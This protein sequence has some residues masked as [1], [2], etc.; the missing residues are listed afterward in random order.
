[1]YFGTSKSQAD[2]SF[3]ST[4]WFILFFIPIFPLRS[5]RII[6]DSEWDEWHS[7][8]KTYQV[9]SNEPLEK[10][11]TI[12]IYAWILVPLIFFIYYAG[13]LSPE[14]ATF[15]IAAGIAFWIIIF[16][17]VYEADASKARN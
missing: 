2:G 7:S 6:L 10:R 17:L 9:V 3:I 15:L 8:G 1:M 5:N 12:E 4:E 11:I 14:F 13:S 16:P